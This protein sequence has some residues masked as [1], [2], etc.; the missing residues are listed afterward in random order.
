MK[1]LLRAKGLTGGEILSKRL[2]GFLA[3]TP[4]AKVGQVIMTVAGLGGEA[5]A[6]IAEYSY[7]K[8]K[9]IF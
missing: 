9:S 2:V 4:H 8:I 6:N 3:I 5:G 7:D 1:I